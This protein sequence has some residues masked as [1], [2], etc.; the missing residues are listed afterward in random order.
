MENAHNSEIKIYNAK[1]LCLFISLDI[2]FKALFIMLQMS[3]NRDIGVEK[4]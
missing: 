3:N 2:L 1:V 4:C